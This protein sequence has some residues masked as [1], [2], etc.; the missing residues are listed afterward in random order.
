MQIIEML[1][2]AGTHCRSGYQRTGFRGITVHNTSNWSNGATAIAHANYLRG[3]GQNNYVSWHYAIDKD[4][5]V[6][7]I[8]ENEVAWCAGDGNGDGN[9]KTINIEICDNADG[10]I[11]MA[12][13]M[14]HIP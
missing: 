14:V 4:Y 12:T 6:R 7:C 13:D 9:F 10:N 5:A 3:S 1:A 2:P 11:R 8:P